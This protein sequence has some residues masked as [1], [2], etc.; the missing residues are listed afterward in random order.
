MSK[1]ILPLVLALAL[2]PFVSFAGD[3]TGDA[4]A[5]PVADPARQSTIDDVVLQRLTRVSLV[6]GDD[7]ARQKALNFLGSEQAHRD[8]YTSLQQCRGCHAGNPAGW[9]LEA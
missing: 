2:A 1:I 3:K 7:D 6:A 9:G 8:A 5:T 4:T